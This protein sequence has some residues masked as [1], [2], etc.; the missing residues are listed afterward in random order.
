MIKFLKRIFQTKPKAILLDNTYRIIPAFEWKGE[1]YYMHEDPMNTATGR[2]LTAM[3]FMEEVLMRCSVDYLKAHV[4][5]CDA[6]FM[7]PKKINLPA[8]IKLNSNLRERINLLVALPEHVYKM[9]S[10]VFFT[11]EESPYRYDQAFNKKKIKA[12]SE[13][14]CMYDFFLQTP[15]KNLM[16]FL[17]LPESNSD[18]YLEVVDKI[19]QFH[20]KDLSEILS[21]KILTTDI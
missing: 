19:N 13:E 21:R 1:M 4:E 18:K 8:L 14:Q 10:I 20:L 17:T 6:V 16:P 9:A 3:M 7:D 15:L 12:W 2:G 11:K 5:A